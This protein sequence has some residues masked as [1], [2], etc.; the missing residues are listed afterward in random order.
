MIKQLS[1]LGFVALLLMPLAAMATDLKVGDIAPDFKL[2]ATDG[3]FYQLSDYKG[4]QN[5]V[6]AWYPMANT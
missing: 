2:Q 3:H 5:L 4:K 1:K 6:L